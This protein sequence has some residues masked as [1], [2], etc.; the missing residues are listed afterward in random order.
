LQQKGLD[1]A[2]LLLQD[3]F[4]QV[5]EHE[6]MAAGE[7]LD[8]AGGVLASLHESPLQGNGGQLQAGDPAFGSCFQRGDVVR[9]KVQ[10]HH[11]VEECGGF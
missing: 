6:M 8:K 11:L 10:A 4:D 1:A 9:G 2:G 3:L 7:G 5:V